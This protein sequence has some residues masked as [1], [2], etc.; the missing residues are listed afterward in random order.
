MRKLIHFC[1]SNK[2]LL[3]NF[4]AI[5][6]SIFLNL[7]KLVSQTNEKKYPS[8]LWEITGNS[9]NKPS[10]L[11]GTMHVSSKLVFH[12]GDEFYNAIKSSDV[13]ALELNPMQW[14]N[15]L[16]ILD[17]IQ[18]NFYK[19]YNDVNQKY[20]NISVLKF[21]SYENYISYALKSEPFLING[22]LFRKTK[23]NEDFEED[24]YLDLYIY[25]TGKRL[26][27]VCTGLENF[28][29][30]QRIVGE[31][32]F[33]MYYDKLK[34]KDKS[35]NS[36]QSEEK[37]NE[38]YRNGDL[39]ML[40]SINTKLIVSKKF[41]D[42]FLLK[43]NEIQAFSI[44]SIIKS[45]KSIFAGVGA[46]HLPGTQ[47][48]IEILR[49]KGYILKPIKMEDKVSSQ[50][51]KLDKIQTPFTTKKYESKN[52]DYTINIPE[53]LYSNSNDFSYLNSKQVANMSNSVYYCVTK[54]P[55]YSCFT[56]EN[57]NVILSKIDSMLYENI[58]GKIISKKSIE[59]N[60]Y[61]G[62]L[63]TNKTRNGD[64][65]IY[66]IVVNTFD[67]LIF[68]INGV[69][70][71][72]L[73][74]R[75]ADNFIK[76]INLNVPKVNPTLIK[77]EKLNFSILFPGEPSKN[78]ITGNV[79][80]SDIIEYKFLSKLNDDCYLFQR[81]NYLSNNFL[82]SDSFELNLFNE[83]FLT[84]DFVSYPI[85]KKYFFYKSNPAIDLTYKTKDSS[86]LFLRVI[87]NKTNYFVMIVKSKSI[88][89]NPND[90]FNT[91]NFI[92]NST[93]EPILYT[94]QN[95]FFS[96][97]T[98]FY[99]KFDS[100]MMPIMYK[101][102][103]IFSN[104]VISE[105]EGALPENLI[106]DFL[107]INQTYQFVNKDNDESVKVYFYQYQKYESTPDSIKMWNNYLDIFKKNKGFVLSIYKKSYLNGWNINEF[108]LSDTGTNKICRYK[109]YM[110]LNRFYSISTITDSI[111]Y[112][113]KWVNEFYNTFSPFNPVGNQ[114]TKNKF[115]VFVKDLN[116]TN[117][118]IR[119]ACRNTF[120]KVDCVGFN[121][122]LKKII[123]NLSKNE[124]NYFSFKRDLIYKLGRT[125]DSTKRKEIVDDIVEIY[126]NSS[127]TVTFQNEAL[128]A[129][130]EQHT[131]ES[132]T[133]LK[134]L[135][136]LDPPDLNTDYE[137]YNLFSNFFDSLKLSVNLFPEILQLTNIG[138]YK[139]EVNLLLATLIDSNLIN[140]KIYENYISNIL[141]DAKF[142][143]KK[144]QKNNE[145]ILEKEHIREN[146]QKLNLNSKDVVID[147]ELKDENDNEYNELN[148][149]NYKKYFLQSPINQ[150]SV[151]LAPFY[152]TNVGVQKY[153]KKL[154][155]S[156]DT[157]NIIYTLS[158]LIKNNVFMYNNVIDSLV[159]SNRYCGT[160]F[161]IFNENKILKFFP[162][163]KTSKEQISS[164]IL[165]KQLY[166]GWDSNDS[167]LFIGK[168]NITLNNSYGDVFFFILKQKKVD[169]CRIGYVGLY[170]NDSLNVNE[171]KSDTLFS[172]LSI[173]ELGID[174]IKD[175]NKLV[176]NEYRK[177]LIL[178]KE[179]GRLFYQSDYEEKY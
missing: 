167:L 118:D 126:R 135:L 114:L 29:E 76:S 39:D 63:I 115:Y 148:T 91:L 123:T 119:D 70:D 104:P 175:I 131:F 77:D 69:G 157:T 144:L 10:Y 34:K 88:Y 103:R 163:N 147:E 169:K 19:Y 106:N 105:T 113:S 101:N 178:N 17:S 57:A 65:H 99:P 125:N 83:S 1:K 38:A 179:S 27:K 12:L 8:L 165:K 5:L 28:M 68:R 172:Y 14:Q 71:Y 78:V 137:G 48:V 7:N 170:N 153:F 121:K 155:S 139:P 89:F 116:N 74:S 16:V 80:N 47:G 136:I 81:H 122:E 11:F 30:S 109:T 87:R 52:G 50:K 133:A 127:D 53:E 110:Q 49:Q 129:L 142:E 162:F 54:I 60:N 23:S 41:N 32:N 171:F 9:L 151:L 61:K 3:L 154:I 160:L 168:R 45:N 18:N 138:A 85:E 146:K 73:K 33:D 90:F 102:N 25:Q 112:C 66:I 72:L 100:V 120:L 141:F 86:K 22:L 64:Y 166:N 35:N 59:I 37:I 107:G 62:L 36:Y 177:M 134:E 82:E 161:K 15:N 21:P 149:L 176:D 43:R 132:I 79:Y 143:L 58:P 152:N 24:T 46:A 42:K 84:N 98:P 67:I 26:G 40:D 158:I 13:V 44:D 96:V 56:G 97:N 117:Q 145:I 4:I 93:P 55:T 75:D 130:Y 159:N 20:F 174:K 108:I 95:G 150:Y 31:A 92:E 156:K 164:S 111:N 128:L 94:D 6:I 124:K 173:V 2:F 140:P 51:D